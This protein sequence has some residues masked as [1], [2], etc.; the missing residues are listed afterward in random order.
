MPAKEGDFSFSDESIKQNSYSRKPA[1]FFKPEEGNRYRIKFMNASATMRLR[2]WSAKNHRYYR[3]LQHEGYCP[4]CTAASDNPG[5]KVWK[6][7]TQSF[8]TTILVYDTDPEGNLIKP[9]NAHPAF[10]A[11]S[12]EKFIQLRSIQNEWGQLTDIDLIVEAGQKYK[13][14]ISPARKCVFSEVDENTR[15][16]W[17]EEVKQTNYPAGKFLAKEVNI[18]TMCDYFN[19]PL[20]Q[21]PESIKAQMDPGQLV[22]ETATKNQNQTYSKD[23]PTQAPKPS[24]EAFASI[25]DIG[26]LL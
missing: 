6:A 4:V 20:S 19:I 22:V 17:E 23:A 5:S 10:W 13:L 25:D 8:G 12:T 24:T 3:C 16:R 2:H 11:F 21:I 9:V 26:K 14:S 15:K 1:N 18:A 7:A